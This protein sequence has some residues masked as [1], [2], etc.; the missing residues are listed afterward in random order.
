MPGTQKPISAKNAPL[1][2]RAFL[3]L[4]TATLV[5]APALSAWGTALAT[6]GERKLS[7]VHTH[8]SE[9]VSSLAYFQNGSYVDSNLTR[10]NRLLRDFRSQDVHPIDPGLF[11]FLYDLQVLADRDEPYEIISGYRSPATNTMLRSQSRGVATRSL[12]MEGQA[13]DV[14]MS[15]VSCKR[16]RDL[17]L[18]MHRGGVGYYAS[19]NFV[20]LD[21]GRVR[22]W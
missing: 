21:T 20:H 19:S 22:S 15:G 2:R 8:T 16:L 14:R 4:S 5:A 10:L 12:H 13:I 17:A 3:R 6:T 11:D 7:F 18:T 9:S 1:S